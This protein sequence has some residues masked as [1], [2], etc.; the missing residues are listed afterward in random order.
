MKNKSLGIN[1][2]YNIIY[3]IL[4]VI[5][6]LISTAYVSRVLLADGVGKVAAVNNNISYFL[7][8]ATLGIPVYGLREI[9]KKR[10]KKL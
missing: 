9:A 2:I 6:P 4:S 10:E 3:K 1:A 5:F 7:I 8:F